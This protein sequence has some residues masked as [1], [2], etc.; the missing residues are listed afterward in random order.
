MN[1]VIKMG[2]NLEVGSLDPKFRH[3]ERRIR[4]V[5]RGLL[6][7]TGKEKAALGVYLVNDRTMVKNVLAF[8]AP[9]QFPYP[10]L[11]GT[12]L[13]EVYVNPDYIEK[14]GENLDYMLVHGYLHLLGYVHEKKDARITMERRERALMRKLNLPR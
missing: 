5:A 7:L 3:L 11:P 9:K 6:R 13:G 4:L 1:K 12:Y 2:S 10:N 8:P 14:N